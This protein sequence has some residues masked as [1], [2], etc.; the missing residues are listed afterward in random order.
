M[1]G[2]K[3]VIVMGRLAADANLNYTGT[4]TP[5]LKFR[6]LSNLGTKNKQRVEATDCVIWGPLAEKVAPHLTKGRALLIDGEPETSS[7]EKDGQKHYREEVR[8]NNFNFVGGN[9]NAATE[10]EPPY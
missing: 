4:G 5:Y 6:L 7:W 2:Y 1:F 8:V 3:K 9:K 10:E